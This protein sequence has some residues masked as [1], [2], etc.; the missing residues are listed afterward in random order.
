MEEADVADCAAAGQCKG[1]GCDRDCRA[2][3]SRTQ[4]CRMGR[5]D[6]MEE[7][8]LGRALEGGDDCQDVKGRAFQKEEKVWTKPLRC[9]PAW[10]NG[11]TGRDRTGQAGQLSEPGLQA[12]A[13]LKGSKDCHRAGA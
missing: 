5:E 12:G 2:S 4:P 9:D 13:A 3:E 11:E 7:E 10:T 8:I 6:F 1:S